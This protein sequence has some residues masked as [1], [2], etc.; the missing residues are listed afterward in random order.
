MR[1]NRLYYT[2]RDYHGWGAFKTFKVKLI[3]IPTSSMILDSQMISKFLQ[4]DS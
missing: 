1:N 2:D 3:M 4:K